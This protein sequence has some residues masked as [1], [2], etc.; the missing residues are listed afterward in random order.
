MK[1][2]II[3]SMLMA[4]TGGLVSAEDRVIAL[5]NGDK[6]A[7]ED[8]TKKLWWQYSAQGL[9]EMIDE[10][11][12]LEEAGRLKVKY[13]ARE[14]EKRFEALSSGYKDKKEFENNLR[15]VGWTPGDVKGLIKRQLLIKNTVIAARDINPS[16]AEVTAFFEQNKD[17][18]G[19][20]DSAR[21][22]QL[23]VTSKAEADDAYLALSAGADFAKLS[24]LKSTD[25]NLRKKEGDIGYISR[26]LLLPEIEKT[27]FSLKPGEYTK[28][29]PT[30]NGFSIF[31]LE[32][33][34]PGEPA[35]LDT[36]LKAELKAGMINQAVSQK[37]P[38]LA[39]E[40]RRK[41]KIEIVK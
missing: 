17:K 19:K 6:I 25:E 34:K 37:L 7:F 2:T 26:G 13:D 24:S 22:R 29:M 30:G 33:L 3:F 1:N 36:A 11:L 31:K 18:L 9:S 14:A 27:V 8:V 15:A 5:V 28:P 23:F 20:A 16:D 10:K 38:E 32:S 40:L 39:A 35:R 4:L 21:L 12:L 41:A